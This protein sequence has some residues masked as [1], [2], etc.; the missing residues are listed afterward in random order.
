M[1][2]YTAYEKI[3]LK[4]AFQGMTL[5][6]AFSK[7][8]DGENCPIARCY[9]PSEFSELCTQ[10]GF[11]NEFVGGYLSML[12]LDLVRTHRDQALEDIRLARE[13]REFLGALVFDEYGFP[14]Y[15]GKYAGVGGV[16]KLYKP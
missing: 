16:Y 9:A 15:N 4:N 11:K 10:A 8:T 3:I 12:E 1:H 7:N 2:L 14:K 6:E 5:D 13:H